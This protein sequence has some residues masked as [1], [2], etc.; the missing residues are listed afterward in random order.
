MNSGDMFLTVV[1]PVLNRAALIGEMLAGIKTQTVRGFELVVVDNGS[2]DET[3]S[4]VEAWARDNRDIPVRILREERRGASAARQRGL[5]AVSTPWTLFFDSDDLMATDHIALIRNAIKSR[6]D[7]ELWG[8]DISSPTG[9]RMFF[10]PR[11]DPW[12]NLIH[13]S[14]STQRYCARTYI[15]HRAGGWNPEM[16]L[17]DDIELGQ[18]IIML[19][20]KAAKISYVKTRVRTRFTPGSITGASF[21]GMVERMERPLEVISAHLPAE[22][23]PIVDFKRAVLYGC[24][25]RESPSEAAKL[26][27]ALLDRQES[28]SRKRLLGVAYFAYC[29]RL[30]GAAK[31]LKIFRRFLR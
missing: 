15:F 16:G 27:K 13:G 12:S 21:S 20:P 24:M 2:T 19:K 25:H 18:R 1:V 22:Q 29:H 10:D 26:M 3:V 17:W 31:V 11:M 8:W 23:R 4:V 30:R 7:V 14:L 28:K 9:S 5:E 6:P